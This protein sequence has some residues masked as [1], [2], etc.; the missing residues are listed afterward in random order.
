MLLPVNINMKI[1][2]RPLF[3]KIKNLDYSLDNIG[4]A[5]GMVVAFVLVIYDA[6]NED[7]PQWVYMT[8]V[9]ASI[10]F[11]KGFKDDLQKIKE[12]GLPVPVS[13]MDDI[14]FDWIFNTD[15]EKKIYIGFVN[16]EILNNILLKP[17]ISTQLIINIHT[18]SSLTHEQ[19]GDIFNAQTKNSSNIIISNTPVDYVAVFEYIKG[20]CDRATF[21]RKV[22]DSENSYYSIRYAK[23]NNLLRQISDLHKESYRDTS[24]IIVDS[25][26]LMNFVT[27]FYNERDIFNISDLNEGGMVYPIPFRDEFFDRCTELIKQA[28]AEILGID[29][30]PFENWKSDGVFQTYFDAHIRDEKIDILDKRRIKIINFDKISVN[31]DIIQ[32]YIKKMNEL[33]VQVRFLDSSFAKDEKN[34]AVIID[35]EVCVDFKNPEKGSQFGTISFLPKDIILKRKKF[36]LYWARVECMNS[37]ELLSKVNKN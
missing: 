35:N 30:T 36:D 18:F 15:T 22:I 33:N 4:L 8:A 21:I 11:F 14:G 23:H 7:A 25:N 17:H 37:D 24:S 27:K 2:L 5:L 3:K 26:G 28:K 9:I 16:E 1:Y 12:D 10:T 6:S 13:Y 34:G 31:L 29:L 19:R 32:M 20:L